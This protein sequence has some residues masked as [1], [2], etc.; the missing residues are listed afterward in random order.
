MRDATLPSPAPLQLFVRP[1]VLLLDE[2]TNHLDLGSVVWLEE[3]LATYDKILVVN[4]HSQVAPLSCVSCL[5]APRYM[6]LVAEC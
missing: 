6:A 5:P 1:T 3:Y 2:P 4:S